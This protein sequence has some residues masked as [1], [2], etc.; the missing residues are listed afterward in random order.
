MET[1]PEQAMELSEAMNNI[2]APLIHTPLGAIATT[3][4]MRGTE[5][6]TSNDKST[7]SHQ[8]QSDKIFTSP[9]PQEN[10]AVASPKTKADQ[11]SDEV[12]KLTRSDSGAESKQTD[13]EDKQGCKMKDYKTET[14][15]SGVKCHKTFS[16]VTDVQTNLAKVSVSKKL[17]HARLEFEVRPKLFFDVKHMGRLLVLLVN[18]RLQ[19]KISIYQNCSYFWRTSDE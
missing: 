16:F 14:S 17:C 6:Q 4:T 7:P 10:A 11:I 19:L 18:I 13:K 3:E 5:G 12:T 9:M 1:S 15:T 2:S 8:S